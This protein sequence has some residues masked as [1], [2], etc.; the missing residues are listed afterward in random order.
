MNSDTTN[1]LFYSK[2]EK[3]VFFIC[4]AGLVTVL[5]L[6]FFRYYY[7]SDKI[8][9]YNEWTTN[10]NPLIQELNVLKLKNKNLENKMD[11]IVNL[12]EVNNSSNTN[13]LIDKIKVLTKRIDSLKTRPTKNIVNK[14]TRFTL[15]RH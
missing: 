9:H 14:N 11:S 13:F 5:F 10:V 15:P 4:L 7:L 3:I 8:D 2:A 1:K 6:S 12:K